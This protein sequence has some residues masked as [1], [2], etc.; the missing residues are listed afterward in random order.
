MSSNVKS[1]D[2]MRCVC[3]SFHSLAM[4]NCLHVDTGAV[5]AF[6]AGVNVARAFSQS[7][8]RMS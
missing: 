3:S 4:K 7:R 2:V 1:R 8:K 5:V 6:P